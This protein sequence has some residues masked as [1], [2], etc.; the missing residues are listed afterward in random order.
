LRVLA[1][2]VLHEG[3]VSQHDRLV[4]VSRFPWGEQQPPNNIRTMTVGD[5]LGM[6]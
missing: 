5:V 3:L 2:A 4:V 6:A 1:R